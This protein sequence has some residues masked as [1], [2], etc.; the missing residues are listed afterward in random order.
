M[1]RRLFRLGWLVPACAIEDFVLDFGQGAWRVSDVASG[2]DGRQ[3]IRVDRPGH[4]NPAAANQRRAVGATSSD[5]DIEPAHR[6]E[7]FRTDWSE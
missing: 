3:A 2:G 6:Q 4:R 5:H 1:L 7:F